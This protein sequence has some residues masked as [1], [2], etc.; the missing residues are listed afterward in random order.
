MR[1]NDVTNNRGSGITLFGADSNLLKTNHVENNGTDLGDTTDGIRVDGASTSNQIL[2]NH[3]DN[4]VT[5]DCHDDSTGP[6]T[7]GTANTWTNDQGSTENRPG[8]CN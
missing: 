5:H 3:M 8:L 4:N 6:G 1:S 2:E 7:G